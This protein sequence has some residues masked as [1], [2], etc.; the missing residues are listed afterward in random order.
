[1]LQPIATPL[2]AG[3]GSANRIAGLVLRLEDDPAPSLILTTLAVRG[4]VGAVQAWV[5]A[6][7]ADGAR[8]RLTPGDARQAALGLRAAA[9]PLADLAAWA[10]SLD[11]AAESAE[12]Q[13]SAVLLGQGQGGGVTP[14]HPFWRGRA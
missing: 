5:I 1:M 12:R 9:G 13:A 10:D 8:E 4:V 11:E 2:T 6:H 14:A 3:D 7:L